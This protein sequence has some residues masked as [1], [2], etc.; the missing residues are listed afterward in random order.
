[1]PLGS[2]VLCSILCFSRT[3]DPSDY[4]IIREATAAG[5][6]VYEARRRVRAWEK[7][8]LTNK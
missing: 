8:I 6:S 2:A 3:V 4:H 7:A 1:M 5:D